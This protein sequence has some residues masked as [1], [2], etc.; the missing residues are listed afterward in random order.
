METPDFDALA[1][2]LHADLVR[3]A[4]WRRVLRLLATVVYLF[5]FCWLVFVLLGGMLAARIGW[6][7][8]S[9]LTTYIFQLL[10]A[11]PCS[12]TCCHKLCWVFAPRARSHAQNHGE[13][14]PVG[15]FFV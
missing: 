13:A 15:T 8:Y 5:V 6:E 11:L 9:R 12:V 2:G 14:F 1:R 7:N 3:V 10:Q 4:G